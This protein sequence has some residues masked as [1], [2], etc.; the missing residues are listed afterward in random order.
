MDEG[1][2]TVVET[3]MKIQRGEKV[4]IVT[5]N[6]GMSIG[7]K[8]RE[9][10]LEK[11]THV[12]FFN[13]DIYG[14]RPLKSLP[15]RI[16]KNAEEA[17][18]TFF[19]AR[20]VKGELD[21]IRFPLIKAG[22]TAGRHAH[23][24]GLTEEIVSK[25]LDMDYERVAEFTNKIYSM[26]KDT[27]E[28]RVR[29]EIGTDFKAKVGRYKWV[30]STGICSK[31]VKEAGEWL[32]LPDGEVY[33]TPTELQ[34]TV[35]INGAIGDFFSDMFDLKEIKK[36][37]LKLEIEQRGK[38]TIVDVESKNKKLEE[39]FEKYINKHECS[40]WIGVIGFGT[41]IFIDEEIGKVVM[42]RKAPNAHIAAG[43]P[44]TELTYADWVCPES[45]DL[46]IPRCDIWFDDEKIMEDGEYIV[47]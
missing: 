46:L 20:T 43:H 31:D 32:N 36:R 18:A 13:L 35:V 1:I 27:D 8:I 22:A 28:I 37:P 10:V 23:M 16:Q 44:N 15:E 7:K 38:A 6:E 9:T 5:D 12:R 29:S 25:G 45:V 24:I 47:T 2:R 39:E 4:V 11:T 30:S 26:A 33:T 17:T 34:G 41:N 14:E 19:T 42:D 40:K 3:C 21:P